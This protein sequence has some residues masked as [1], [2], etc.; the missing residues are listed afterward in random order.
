M[1]IITKKTNAVR[2]FVIAVGTL[3]VAVPIF[4]HMI[5][6]NKAINE[7]IYVLTIIYGDEEQATQE[8]HRRASSW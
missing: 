3:I 6:T 4:S 2:I 8:C 7:C 1:K 5:K